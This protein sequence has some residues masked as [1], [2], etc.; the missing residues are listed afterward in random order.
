[1]P[2]MTKQKNKADKIPE[3]ELHEIYHNIF[4]CEI[5]LLLRNCF[6]N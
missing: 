6:G 2:P 4:I 3:N 5:H 1:M